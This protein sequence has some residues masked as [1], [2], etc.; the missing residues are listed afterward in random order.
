MCVPWRRIQ[1]IFSGG[2]SFELSCMLITAKAFSL[3]TCISYIVIET[4][5]GVIQC[6]QFNMGQSMLFGCATGKPHT[7]N[8]VRKMESGLKKKKKRKK[9]LA[10]SIFKTESIICACVI[11]SSIVVI[12]SAIRNFVFGLS[13]LTTENLWSSNLRNYFCYFADIV[14]SL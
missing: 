9:E 11:A 6:F 13:D 7:Q 3:L 8:E 2:E 5:N 4:L 10:I 14:T 12:S 1:Y